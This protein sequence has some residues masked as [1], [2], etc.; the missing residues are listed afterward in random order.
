MPK[1]EMNWRLCRKKWT[2]YLL[3][4]FWFGFF[5][6]LPPSPLGRRGF[7]SW[8]LILGGA[9]VPERFP[10]RGAH[11][12]LQVDPGVRDPVGISA[13]GIAVHRG[14][15][16]HKHNQALTTSGYWTPSE[17]YQQTASVVES[18]FKSTLPCCNH[19]FTWSLTGIFGRIQ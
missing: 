5:P 15:G 12:G 11:R 6:P 2:L 19:Y 1:R 9:A 10:A 4:L 7:L 16:K 17:K 14:Q 13:R 8:H 18:N 3:L